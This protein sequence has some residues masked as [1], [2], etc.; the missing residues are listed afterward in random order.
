[1]N[2]KV[3]KILK[4][5]IY[6]F[7]GLSVFVFYFVFIDYFFDNA[8]RVA[9]NPNLNSA[10]DYSFLNMLELKSQ[11]MFMWIKSYTKG[12]NRTSTYSK[13]TLND[14]VSKDIM[15][16]AIDE[17][18]LSELGAWPFPRY[19][20]KKLVD[21]F[22]FSKYRENTLFF[23]VFFVE[24]DTK[25]PE[26]DYLLT[27][28]VSE[29]GRVVM[30]LMGVDEDFSSARQK[31]E[32]LSRL[33]ELEK[34]N[35][36]FKSVRGRLEQ[37]PNFPSLTLPLIPYIKSMENSGF[38]NLLEDSDKIMRRFPLIGRFNEDKDESFTEITQGEIYDA[39]IVKGP[40]INFLKS[41]NYYELAYKDVF[42]YDQRRVATDERKKLTKSDIAQIKANIEKIYKDFK[43]ECEKLKGRII[44]NRGKIKNEVLDFV[45]KSSFSNDFKKQIV[46]VFSDMQ[47]DTDPGIFIDQ[48][49]SYI[50]K[51][52]E[53][54]D[55]WDH[56]YDF[57]VNLKNKLLN[58]EHQ[59][60]KVVEDE[61]GKEIVLNLSSVLFSDYEYIDD[62]LIVRKEHFLMSMP[63]LLIS[64]YFNVTQQQIEI[65]IGKEVIIY[66]PMIYNNK[67]ELVPY[68]T[69]GKV[70]DK[71]SIPID[72]RGYL[73]INYA[74]KPS[75][76]GRS[77]ETTFDVYSYSDFVNKDVSVLVRNKIAMVG[78]FSSGMADDAYQTPFKTMYGIEVIANTVNTVI[79]GNF[80]R[81]PASIVSI[82]ILLFLSMLIAIIGANRNII[83]SYIYVFLVYIFYFI[84]A[85]FMFVTNNYVLEVV[86]PLIVTALSLTSVIV[87][88]VFT[89]EKQKKQ[90]KS[91]FSKYV[92][93][94]VVEELL[95]NPPALGGN[96]M[97]ITVQFSDIRGFTTLSESMSPQ[98]LVT[99]LNQY[100]TAMTNI[101]IEENGT[102]D[103]YIGD[104]IMCF[105]GAPHPDQL[106]AVKACRAA[107]RQ[108]E[109]LDDINKT[110]PL[111]KQ[112]DIGIGLNSGI[113][114]A[115]NMGSE[116]Q[117]NYTIMGDN[118][119]LGSRLEGTNKMYGTNIIVSEYTYEL[120]K[121]DFIFRE[122]DIIRVKGKN[123][124][125]KIYELLAFKGDIGVEV[126]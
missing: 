108:M 54:D 5:L 24:P 99:L 114:T 67:N 39:I 83:R 31:S 21:Y 121:N 61:D 48:I 37:L 19:I 13:R 110:L 97:E 33:N 27:S 9:V 77:S 7:I 98:E 30:D 51:Q 63:M 84:V 66:N 15:I 38:A 124:P 41:S 16:V 88:R 52:K 64:R 40:Y 119:N 3:K 12:V 69:N 116:R 104:A 1:M 102:L 78:A 70:I 32:T 2:N 89:E 72:K 95:R 60:G 50:E 56:D 23:D 125:V 120:A 26:Y 73:A 100:L 123:R 118:V 126:K 115:G 71:L 94:A 25:N 44:E 43:L 85:I 82:V 17:K 11:D 58:V 8:I 91:I 45:D 65:D 68:E 112:I 22:T 113:M 55:K 42:V 47:I 57:F 34:K 10:D 62:T 107:L 96:D 103:K 79:T 76:S 87:Y 28:S 35:T 6:P 90:I 18:S 59:G 36:T 74:G 122:L 81:R 86:K 93:A 49:L 101:I 106:H 4:K 46:S 117:M 14:S 53:N 105:W 109:A 75:S 111:H 20:H 80:L 92:N 29:N